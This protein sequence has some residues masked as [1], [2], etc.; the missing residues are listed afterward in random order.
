MGV[1]S[2][3][4]H[5]ARTVELDTHK[6]RRYCFVLREELE[7]S[8]HGLEVFLH[9]LA[10]NV[11]G[12]KIHDVIVYLLVLCREGRKVK[13]DIVAVAERCVLFIPHS[14]ADGLLRRCRRDDLKIA[15]TLYALEL[16][17]VDLV[18]VFGRFKRGGRTLRIALK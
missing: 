3:V 10:V 11:V 18:Y 8:Q 12:R 16:S 5:E 4:A 9:G 13:N 1:Q 2:L 14:T 7:R 17:E 15:Y 6:G